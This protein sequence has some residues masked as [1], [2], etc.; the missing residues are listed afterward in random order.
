MADKYTVTSLDSGVYTNT[1]NWVGGSAPVANDNIF[2]QFDGTTALAGSDQSATELDDIWVLPTCTGNIGT[3]DTYLQLDQGT[4]NK[5]IYAGRGTAYI[6]L[7]TAGSTLVEVNQ[8]GN[9]SNGR[10]GLYLKNNTNAITSM[11]V[12][13][14]NVRLVSC[15]VTTLTV[16]SGA[17]VILDAAS[18]VATVNNDGGTVI[19]YGAAITTINNRLGTTTKDGSDAYAVNVYGGVVYNDGTGTATAVVYGGTFDSARDTRSKSVTLTL[20]SGTAVIGPTVT[21]TDTL[22]DITTLS[23]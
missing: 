18:T 5:L 8:T 23:A 10:S 20:N 3:A 11:V 14:G 7:G 19:D 15:N 2:M 12:N 17:T 16:R 4:A 21:L 1:A 6:D 13:D 9:A 22:N